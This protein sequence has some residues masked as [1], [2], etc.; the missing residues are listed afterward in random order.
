LG[1]HRR[2]DVL[3]SYETC[4]PDVAVQGVAKLDLLL[5]CSW[6]TLDDGGSTLTKSEHVDN[7]L[8]IRSGSGSTGSGNAVSRNALLILVSAVKGSKDGGTWAKWRS[9]DA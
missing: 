5:K 1:R 4:R 2:G 9:I 3:V 6:Q 8:N 7:I